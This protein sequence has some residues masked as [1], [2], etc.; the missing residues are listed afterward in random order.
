[1]RNSENV[2]V[3]YAAPK[4][5]DVSRFRTGLMAWFSF[6]QRKFYWRTDDVSNYIKIVSEVLLQRTQAGVVSSFLPTFLA[7]FPSW[8]AI[9]QSNEDEIGA[10][11]KPLGLWRR[12]AVSLLALAKE[13]SHRGGAW[14]LTR[15]ELESIP[16]VG[17][18]VASAVLLFEHKERAPLLDASMAR[19]LRRYF[20]I[21]PEKA[22]I[23][24]D[25][26]LHTIAHAVLGTGDPILLNW[27]MLDFA[28]L[29]CRTN[30]GGCVS[31]VLKA[32]CEHY[33]QSP[34]PDC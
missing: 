6:N 14:P 23:R 4:D 5:I 9:A 2:P 31:C 33:A 22:D 29:Q 8:D 11:L 12:R 21:T 1:M 27:A 7:T 3:F 15:E 26:P 16:A 19:L 10:L 30:A 32:E 34:N 25:R 28:A 20:A 18:Y 17:Q 24:Y 13:I